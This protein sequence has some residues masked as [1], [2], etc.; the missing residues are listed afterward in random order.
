MNEVLIR[1]GE[2]KLPR[3]LSSYLG[4]PKNKTN[5]INYTF[6]TWATDFQNV[7]QDS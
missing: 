5:L 7:L 1:N 2:Q 6:N 3:D 4:N